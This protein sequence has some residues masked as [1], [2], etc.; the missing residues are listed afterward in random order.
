MP[1]CNFNGLL[2]GLGTMLIG[3]KIVL[4]RTR[5]KLKGIFFKKYYTKFFVILYFLFFYGIF[6]AKA[7]DFSIIIE[8]IFSARRAKNGWLNRIHL[9]KNR[10]S[11][12]CCRSCAARS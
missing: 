5:D 3:I 7:E 11:R 2:P 12:Q 6:S 9:P 8:K 1:D 10:S 4:L